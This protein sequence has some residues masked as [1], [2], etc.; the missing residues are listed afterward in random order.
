VEELEKLVEDLARRALD[1]DAARRDGTTR[2]LID[3]RLTGQASIRAKSPGTIS[4][5]EAAA[6]VFRLVDRSVGYEPVAVNGSSVSSGGVVAS[7]SGRLSSMLSAERTALNF[8]QHLSGIS[9]LTA[10]YVRRVK[11]SGV[12]ILD[13][14]K[15]VPGLRILEKR[16][17]VHG[18]GRNHRTDLAG[19]MLVKENHITA[20]GGLAAVVERLGGVRLREA[21][22]EVTS[23]DELRMLKHSPPRRIMLDNFSP[24]MLENALNELRS[25]EDDIP[26]V[27]VSG[28]I[29]LQTVAVFARPGVDY[30]SVGSI[31]SSAPAL[32]LSMTIDKV[33][34]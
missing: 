26:E 16:A 23:L 19:M 22:I 8:L 25:W 9:T 4:G 3:E 27:E 21:E 31:T 13:T 17:V 5:H 12:V 28:G 14:R 18:G 15:T 1:E 7:V 6:A 29:T 33:N 34:P 2:L 24:E 11:G 20:A 32:D 30:V 10:E